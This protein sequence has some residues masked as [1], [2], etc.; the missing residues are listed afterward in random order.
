MP[1]LQGFAPRGPGLPPGRVAF[2]PCR[3]ATPNRP[4]TSQAQLLYDKQRDYE[5]RLA[6][7]EARRDM[8][9]QKTEQTS[10]LLRA[11]RA[12][13]HPMMSGRSPEGV[14]SLQRASP[15]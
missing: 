12:L 2:P 10:T 14:H 1:P 3:I 6:A 8:W 7:R 4:R 15:T 5:E 13:G 9:D 11:E